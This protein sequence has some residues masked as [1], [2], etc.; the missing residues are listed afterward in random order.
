MKNTETLFWKELK[1]KTKK[2]NIL[3]TRIE[4]IASSGTPDLL[5]CHKDCGL[6]TIEL[7]IA[8]NSKRINLNPYQIA[9]NKMHFLNNSNSFILVKDI[10]NKHMTH[11]QG[12]LKLYE[13]SK[14]EILMRKGIDDC[15]SLYSGSSFDDL[16]KCLLVQSCIKKSAC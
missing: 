15:R 4:N 5:F 10:R 9:F 14:A 16:I 12:I 8:K 3:Y 1:E 11:E 7:K 13:G 6:G 2:H